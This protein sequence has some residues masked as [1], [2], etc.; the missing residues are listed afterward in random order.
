MTSLLPF[1]SGVTSWEVIGHGPLLVSP[2]INPLLL[3]Q[4]PLLQ[5]SGLPSVLLPHGVYS[6]LQQL[7]LEDGSWEG[8]SSLISWVVSVGKPGAGEGPILPS[9][10]ASVSSAAHLRPPSPPLPLRR[11]PPGCPSSLPPGSHNCPLTELVFMSQCSL[12]IIFQEGRGCQDYFFPAVHVEAQT[13]SQWDPSSL[14][15]VLW[16]CFYCGQIQKC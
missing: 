7:S 12:P 6:S 1:S 11:D 2:C 5:G 15:P 3:S 13:Q 14:G 4:P 10:P 8:A 9:H 16:L